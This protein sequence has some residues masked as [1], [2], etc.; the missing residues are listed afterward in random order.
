MTVDIHVVSHT[1]W[2]REWY[3]TREQFR[4]RLVDLI[5]RVLDLLERDSAFAHDHLDGQ[6]IV[7]EDY[8]EMRPEQTSRVQRDCGGPA[9]RR[10]V[11][12]HARR[13]PRQR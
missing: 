6:T 10:P 5:D 1:H 8:L 4:L 3:L 11:V 12:R 13:I 9:A 7:L 2:D